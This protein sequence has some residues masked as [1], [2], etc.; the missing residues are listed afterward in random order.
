MEDG[1]FLNNE[2]RIKM[3]ELKNELATLKIE[4][5]HFAAKKGGV[6]PEE[7]ERWKVNSHRTNEVYIEI[8]NLRFKNVIEAGKG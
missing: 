3:E 2:D 1:H 8:K 6:T 7:R 5:K 4:H